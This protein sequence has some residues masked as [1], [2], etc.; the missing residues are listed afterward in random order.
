MRNYYFNKAYAKPLSHFSLFGTLLALIEVQ[1][2]ANLY[3]AGI[4][5]KLT[6]FGICGNYDTVTKLIEDV[7]SRPYV[8]LSLLFFKSEPY[9][10]RPYHPDHVSTLEEDKNYRW[11]NTDVGNRRMAMLA[12]M[13][14]DLTNYLQTEA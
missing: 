3:R 6:V 12:L 9:P 10:I 7:N 1:R 2:Q 13:I 5:N 8:D 11:G 4:K 14:K